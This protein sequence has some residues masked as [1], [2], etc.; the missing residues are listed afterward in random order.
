MATCTT[1]ALPPMT[2]RTLRRKLQKKA[3]HKP[4]RKCPRCGARMTC[5]LL[6]GWKAYAA[7]VGRPIG[8]DD[9]LLFKCCSECSYDEELFWSGGGT[10]RH[11]PHGGNAGRGKA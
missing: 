6:E 1:K 11:I 10:G 7:V 2:P 4:F 3:K 8:D 9:W 5:E